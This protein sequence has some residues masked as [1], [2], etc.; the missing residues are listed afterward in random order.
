MTDP[1]TIE[2]FEIAGFRAYL[3][4]Q[5]FTLGTSKR[6]KSLVVYAPNATG[7][8]SL[9]DAFE[10]Y[11]S[12]KGSLSRLGQRV[13]PTQAG[14]KAMEHVL[15]KSKGVSGRVGFKFKQGTERF[16]GDRVLGTLGQPPSAAK[17]VVESI[18]LPFV[19]RG[20]DLQNFVQNSAEDRY[21]EMAVWF[22]LDPLLNIQKNLRALRGSVRTKSE[23]D[24]QLDV[25]LFDLKRQ[26]DQQVTEWNERAICRWFNSNVLVPLDPS[27]TLNRLSKK[28]PVYIAMVEAEK[29]EQESIGLTTL[30]RL[31]SEVE[32]ISGIKG[33]EGALLAFEASLSTLDKAAKREASER[34]IASQS[35]FNDI[36]NSAD[37]LFKSEDLQIDSCPVCDTKFEDTPHRTCDAVKINIQ[38]KLSTLREYRVAESA[39]RTATREARESNRQLVT[40]IKKLRTGI[41]EA[42]MKPEPGLSGYLTRLKAWTLNDDA[43]K[44]EIF[45]GALNKTLTS[46]KRSKAEIENQQGNNTFARARERAENLIQL[47]GDVNTILRTKTHLVKLYDHLNNQGQIIEDRINQ[48][49]QTLLSD[50]EEEVNR[51]YLKM[52]RP[53][54]PD[55]SK[56]HFWLSP[57]PSKNQQQIRLVVDFAPGHEEV[58]PSGYLSDSQIH[59]VAIALRLAAIRTFNTDAPIVVLDDVVTSYDSDHRKNIAA[60]IAEELEGFQI[61]LVTHD[62]QFFLLLKDHLVESE[63]EFRR[64]TQIDPGYGPVFANYQTPDEIVDDKLGKGQSAGEEI[65][66]I[67]EEWLLKIC[68]EFVVDI[69]IRPI[70]RPFHFERSELAGALSRFLKDKRI[71]PPKIT[72]FMNP[73]LTSLQTGIVENFASHFSDNPNRS[74]SMGDEKARWDEFRAFRNLFRCPKCGHNRFKRPHPIKKPLCNKCETPFEFPD[75]TH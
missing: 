8:S 48:H 41:A 52:Q 40:A 32:A 42:D 6:R 17:R 30:N 53:D 36:W 60:T 61:V 1:I 67:E 49:I 51:L 59:S 72:G 33:K 46:L 58:A 66:K 62:E 12:D 65:R 64:I 44:S 29:K 26:T 5:T 73:F 10:F 69:A 45:L 15:A 68:R 27:L 31:I 20:N 47:K 11:F 18:K 7:K 57:D 38:A 16:E 19:I 9:I 43:P 28:D 13:S 3:E 37:A 39:L 34:N 63:F 74:G 24:G 50:L 70:D 23:S 21:A 2:A 14:P 71:L 54:D 25:R 35:I 22:A 55:S 75:S 4:P 56:V